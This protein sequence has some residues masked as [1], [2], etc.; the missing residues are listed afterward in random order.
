MC[1]KDNTKTGWVRVYKSIINN[2]I[3]KNDKLLKVYIWSLLNATYL[4]KE[5]LVGKQLVSLNPGQ[6][7]TNRNKAS[8]ELGMTLS[9][10][11]DYLKQLENQ[12]II[13][14]MSNNKYSIVTI[15]NW[16]LYQSSDII[17]DNK[18]NNKELAILFNEPNIGF[19]KL[20]RCLKNDVIFSNIKLLKVH[21]WCLLKATHKNHENFVGRQLVKLEAGQFVTGRKKASEELNMPETTTWDYL[22]ILEKKGTIIITS[23]NKF[24]VV[25]V[26]NWELYQSRKKILDSNSDNK[27]TTNGHKQENKELNNKR[28]DT[29]KTFK[30]Y[31]KEYKLSKYLS[32]QISI[33]LN[34]SLQNESTLQKWS[35]IFEKMVYED[36]QNID[37]ILQVLIFSQENA[38]WQ[39]VILD[40]NK[41]RKNFL[42]I[43]AKYQLKNK[44]A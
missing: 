3:F 43:Y 40:A 12:K 20:Y 11:W 32:H 23:N 30:P 7:I 14:I 8:R 37:V 1:F 24:S 2:S 33:R 18:Y 16:D 9:T 29:L 25:T 41:F 13:N 15:E 42:N 44:G 10:A 21:I 17:S 35:V 26:V 31:D 6:F 22:K 27:T 39:S 28:D 5:H 38:F 19:I 36:E 34:Q 4:N